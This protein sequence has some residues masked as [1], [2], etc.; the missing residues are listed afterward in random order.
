MEK[1]RKRFS[2]EKFFAQAC[3][4]PMFI[5]L[6]SSSG[7][8]ANMQRRRR[9]SKSQSFKCISSID[10]LCISA[11]VKALRIAKPFA[12]TVLLVCSTLIEMICKQIYTHWLCICCA[13]YTYVIVCSVHKPVQNSV[14]KAMHTTQCVVCITHKCVVSSVRRGLCGWVNRGG[15]DPY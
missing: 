12:C 13:H 5:R 14:H 1:V 15:S 3:F 11:I 2:G 8:F 4:H 10:F 9:R 7:F 6:I